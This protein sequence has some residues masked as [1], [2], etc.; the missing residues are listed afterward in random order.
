M[1]TTVVEI[2]RRLIHNS[3]ADRPEGSTYEN[4]FIYRYDFPRGGLWERSY[5]VCIEDCGNVARHVSHISGVCL[6]QLRQLRIIRRSLTTDA[7][8]ALVR[9]LIHTL[10]DYCNGLLAYCPRYLTDKLQVVSSPRGR[11]AWYCNYL[12]D[13]LC[14]KSCIGSCTGWM[15]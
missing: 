7:A 3:E 12:T 6:F 9:A 8:H 13:H 15:W 11:Q 5:N 10:I 1:Q 14:R 2:R 4:K